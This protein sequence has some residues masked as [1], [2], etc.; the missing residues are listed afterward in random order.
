MYQLTSNC[1][2][3]VGVVPPPVSPLG[4]AAAGRRSGLQL[5]YSAER[6][7]GRRKGAAAPIEGAPVPP[8]T[9]P[10][11]SALGR[12]LRRPNAYAVRGAAGGLGFGR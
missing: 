1:S 8:P 10:V 2:P 11:A 4:G 9:H 7:P 3:S 12:T 6:R 5:A